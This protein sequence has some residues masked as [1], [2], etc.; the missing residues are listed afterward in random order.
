MQLNPNTRKFIQHE[1]KVNLEKKLAKLQKK[2]GLTNMELL[3]I[4]SSMQST[5]L[6]WEMRRD[7]DERGLNEL[8]EPK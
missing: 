2:Y 6:Y 4:I 7:I 8:R 3:R 1:A 5:I